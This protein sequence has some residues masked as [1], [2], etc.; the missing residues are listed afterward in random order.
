M[1]LVLLHE[2]RNTPVACEASSPRLA[3]NMVGHKYQ[4]A[5]GQDNTTRKTCGMPFEKKST[6]ILTKRLKHGLNWSVHA[7][8]YLAAITFPQP[9]LEKAV[10]RA[11]GINFQTRFCDKK[12]PMEFCLQ[13][14]LWAILFREIVLE[15]PYTLAVVTKQLPLSIIFSRADLMIHSLQMFFRD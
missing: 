6:N 5:I 3:L 2:R 7:T 8:Q 13:G 10:L 14:R 9:Q 12:T 1:S 4:V 15:N 11:N